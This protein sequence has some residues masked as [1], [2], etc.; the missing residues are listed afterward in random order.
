MSNFQSVDMSPADFSADDL[1][2]LQQ[3]LEDQQAGKKVGTFD[4]IKITTAA[5]HTSTMRD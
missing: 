2:T 3:Q 1:A 4:G 5:V